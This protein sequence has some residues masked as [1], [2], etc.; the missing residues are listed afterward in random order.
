MSESKQVVVQQAGYSLVP[1]SFDEAMQIANVLAKSQLVPKDYQDKPANV[2][3]AVQWGQELGL[4]PLQ[5]LQG[6]AVING[7]PAIWGDAALALCQARADFQDIEEKIVGTDKE[8]KA[9]CVIKRKGRAPT[10]VEFSVAD[11]VKANLWGKQ[12]PWT[13]YPD[14]ML[15][16]RARGFALRNSF[17]DAL[18]G[19]KTAEEVQDYQDPVDITPNQPATRVSETV[20]TVSGEVIKA[21]EKPALPDYPQAKF[22]RHY[23][24][25]VAEVD[26]GTTTWDTVKKTVATK[27]KLTEAQLAK[28]NNPGGETA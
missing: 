28:I 15:Q 17:A 22:D 11:A 24:Q 1:K 8:R 2:F 16:M 12:G 13:Q 27:Y 18:K 10:V 21:D 26:A 23:P 3:V 7:R 25:W 9:I 6:I 20:D 4:A 19:F 5:A 14:R